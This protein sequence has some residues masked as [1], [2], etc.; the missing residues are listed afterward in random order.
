[1]TYAQQAQRLSLHG[2]DRLS[3]LGR[4]TFTNGISRHCRIE[5]LSGLVGHKP[6]HGFRA[7]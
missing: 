5:L 4:H 3:P 7:A 1:M 6:A 2:L